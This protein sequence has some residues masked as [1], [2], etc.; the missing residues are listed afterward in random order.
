MSSLILSSHVKR[1][2][3]LGE[4]FDIP[5]DVLNFIE[6][7][8]GTMRMS[9]FYNKAIER[10]VD[11]EEADKLRYPGPKPQIRET[12]IAML[13]DAVEA[14][15]RTLEDPK[16]ARINNLIQRI[17]NDRFQSG[18]LDECPLTLRNLAGIKAAFA[19]VLVASFHHRV[20][21]PTRDKEEMGGK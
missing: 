18:E 8:H 10:G 9:Y 14:A 16:P 11:P 1:G 20:V 4:E 3:W 13:A 6:E 5:D 17:I 21:Y 2:R 19:Q 7:H 12:G 15:S